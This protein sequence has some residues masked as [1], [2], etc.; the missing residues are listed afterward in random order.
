M[1]TK[2]SQEAKVAIEETLRPLWYFKN[3]PIPAGALETSEDPYSW[4][5]ALDGFYGNDPDYSIRDELNSEVIASVIKMCKLQNFS[6]QSLVDPI[7][8][9]LINKEFTRNGRGTMRNLVTGYSRPLDIAIAAKF[10]ENKSRYATLD[11]Y[12]QQV[13][14]A[15]LIG[16]VMGILEDRLQRLDSGLLVPR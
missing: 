12:S 4:I 9:Q 10:D 2:V 8:I 7:Q 3:T 16:R 6:G 1:N 14:S 11:G 5:T 13:G 15:P